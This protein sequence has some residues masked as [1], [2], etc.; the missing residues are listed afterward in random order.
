[1]SMRMVWDRRQR[2]GQLCF[3]SREGRHGISHEGIRGLERLRAPRSNQRIDIVGIGGKR[4]IEEGARLRNIVRGQT[5]VEPSHA[6]K[7]KVRRVGGRRLLS[8]TRLGRD[9]LS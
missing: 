2:F 3:G 7:V 4:T 9:K 8:A 6:L 1:M 5:L